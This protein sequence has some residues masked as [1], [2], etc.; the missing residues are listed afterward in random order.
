MRSIDPA[1]ILILIPIVFVGIIAVAFVGARGEPTQGDKIAR[2]FSI[3]SNAAIFFTVLALVYQVTASEDEA[4]RASY[5][6]VLDTYYEINRL[7]IDHPDVWRLMYPD[8]DEFARL[9]EDER[10][11]LQYTYF[12]LNFFERLYLLHR[13][14]VIDDERWKAW[15]VWIDY[16]LSTSAL[17][18]DVW[19]ESCGLHHADFVT[20]IETTFDDGECQ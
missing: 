7:Q 15:E 17:F 3:A 11:A 16:S 6:D 19:H 20:Y 10:L 5:A 9:G 8:E 4:N 2:F 12:T 13:D 1:L 18:Q 14:G